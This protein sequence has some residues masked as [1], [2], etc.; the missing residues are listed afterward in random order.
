MRFGGRH[1]Q[2]IATIA[3]RIHGVAGLAQRTFDELAGVAIILDDQNAHCGAPQ[4][5]ELGANTTGTW[6]QTVRPGSSLR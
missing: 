4:R 1:E 6:T 3:D 5:P 2:A